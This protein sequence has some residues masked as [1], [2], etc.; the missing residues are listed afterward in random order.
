MINVYMSK[1]DNKLLN[2]SKSDHAFSRFVLKK[3]Y[4]K[5]GAVAVT[6]KSLSCFTQ[7]FYA[8]NPF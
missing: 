5:Y 6:K 4:S 8:I 2:N 1:I 3:F 7:L